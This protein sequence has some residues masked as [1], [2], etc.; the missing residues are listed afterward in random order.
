MSDNDNAQ[1]QIGPNGQVYD[2]NSGG[3]VAS[4]EQGRNKQAGSLVSHASIVT[5]TE[6]VANVLVVDQERRAKR[7]LAEL[8]K[9]RSRAEEELRKQNA[10]IEKLTNRM[11]TNFNKHNHAR[12]KEFIRLLN[13]ESN[14]TM[15]SFNK[16]I[17][18]SS[19]D[20]NFTGN[21]ESTFQY[22][23]SDETVRATLDAQVKMTRI[24]SISDDS[25]KNIA[26]TLPMPEKIEF[27]IDQI[28][29][30][31]KSYDDFFHA[32]FEQ[33]VEKIKQETNRA[34]DITATIRRINENIAR[35]N[36]MLSEINSL[37]RAAR[38]KISEGQ[39]RVSGQEEIL[40]SLISAG[41][42]LANDLLGMGDSDL[43]G[44]DAFQLPLASADND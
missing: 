14:G 42:E 39:M 41:D 10:H 33:E 16:M 34:Q 37:E 32:T 17:G 25:T 18:V 3:L 21:F 24:S 5:S 22:N 23:G 44:S 27:P 29:D 4:S 36:T 1:H 43:F 2:K 12:F 9:T 11:G 7:M 30:I 38:A 28:R 13:E 40:N 15:H 31:R 19:A 35:V 6:D 8:N 26:Y 20:Q